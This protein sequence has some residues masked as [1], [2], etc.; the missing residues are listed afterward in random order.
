MDC[1]HSTTFTYYVHENKVINSF[2]SEPN[3]V[4]NLDASAVKYFNMLL[5]LSLNNIRTL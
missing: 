5:P 1:L 4:H 2:H 3:K